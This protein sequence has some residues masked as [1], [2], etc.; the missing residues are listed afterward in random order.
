MDSRHVHALVIKAYL[1]ITSL[2]RAVGTST[3]LSAR[4]VRSVIHNGSCAC[5]CIYVGLW[6][7]HVCVCGCMWKPSVVYAALVHHN[8]AMYLCAFTCMYTTTVVFVWRV[9]ALCPGEHHSWLVWMIAHKCVCVTVCVCVC[10]RERER[11]RGII[12]FYTVR[13]SDVQQTPWSWLSVRSLHRGGL[14]CWPYTCSCKCTL[15]RLITLYS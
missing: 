12:V 10:V 2:F 1:A 4:S 8:T 14:T 11:E 5:T 3:R 13:G 6:C 15:C 7:V 9:E